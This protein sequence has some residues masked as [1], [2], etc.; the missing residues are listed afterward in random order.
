MIIYVDID[1]T[2][3]KTKGTD[4][5]NSEP[6]Y[7]Q[8]Y[9]INRLYDEGNVIIYWTARGGSER[10][11][12]EGKC[13][14]DFTWKQLESWGC[15]FHDLSTGS[16]GKYIKPACDIVIDDKAKRIEEI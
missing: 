11:K 8:I 3:C 4:Y 13:Y 15:K 1:G 5:N 12:S 7:E 16:K 6:K 14:Y 2:I 10:S 9:K